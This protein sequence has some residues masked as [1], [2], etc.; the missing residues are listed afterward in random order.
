[1]S[2]RK[3]LS[4]DKLSLIKDRDLPGGGA[5]NFGLRAMCHQKDPPFLLAFTEKT[6]FL[7]TF[8]Q[9]PL[10]LTNSLSR[11]WHIFVTQRPLIF[12]FNDKFDEML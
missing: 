6:P 11:P 1:M 8:T 2:L 3:I 9:W 10:F 5:L 12:A 4:Y 7:P